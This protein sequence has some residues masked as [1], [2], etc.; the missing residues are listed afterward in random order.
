MFN[1]LT[2]DDSA[3][4]MNN[5]AENVLLGPQREVL[6]LVQ[7]FNRTFDTD[8]GITKTFRCIRLNV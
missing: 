1:K 3:I 6:E 7:Q 4:D 8:I 5:L 2:L